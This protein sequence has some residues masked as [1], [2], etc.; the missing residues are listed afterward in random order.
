M[1]TDSRTWFYTTPEPRPYYIEERVNQT[2]WKNRLQTLYM[3]CTKATTPIQMEGTWQGSPVRFEWQ[4]GKYFIL[5]TAQESKELIG[6][7]RQILMIRPS[8]SYGSPDGMHVVEWHTDGGSNRWTEL[9]GKP[10]YQGLRRL[11]KD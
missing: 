9:Q 11:R 4:P 2:L 8:L 5:T 6:V 3:N 1:T 10:Q 7:M